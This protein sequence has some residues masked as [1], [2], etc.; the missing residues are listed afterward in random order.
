MMPDKSA[1]GHGKRFSPAELEA[2]R[3]VRLADVIADDLVVLF[4]GANPG[5]SSAAARAPFA[6][7]SD[8]WWPR[9][10]SPGLRL[11]VWPRTKR[12]SSWPWG[13]A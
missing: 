1:A 5:L 10:M 12:T 11:A 6:T 4:C 7:P 9:C 13:L 3:R 2:A 8:R